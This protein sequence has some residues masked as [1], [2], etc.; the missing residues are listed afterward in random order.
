[1]LLQSQLD[2]SKDAVVGSA[3]HLPIANDSVE[4]VYSFIG[5][6]F[7]CEEFFQEAFRVLKIGGLI[8]EILP[9]RLWAETLRKELGLPSDTTYFLD[10]GVKLFAPS[11]VFSEEDLAIILDKI[12]FRSIHVENLS[13]PGDFQAVVP[14]HIQ[15]PSRILRIDPHDLPLLVVVR[16]SK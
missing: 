4:A 3:L 15:I 9:T 7:A 2:E 14:E 1:M 5:D 8:L 10:D 11:T 16:A 13:L 12:G 6:A